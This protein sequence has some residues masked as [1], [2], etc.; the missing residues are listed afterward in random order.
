M[1]TSGRRRH[2]PLIFGEDGLIILAVLII[3]LALAGDIGRQRH[4]A[5]GGN[6]L[7]ENGPME[8]ESER[9]FAALALLFDPRIEGAEKA[10]PPLGAKADPV[11]DREALAGTGERLPA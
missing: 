11:A 6:R 5:Q 2:R 4:V 7:I 8:V 10:D 1:E 9:D 3:R